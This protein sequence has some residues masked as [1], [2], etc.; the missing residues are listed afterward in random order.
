MIFEKQDEGDILKVSFKVSETDSLSQVHA[1]LSP[2]QSVYSHLNIPEMDIAEDIEVH[3]NYAYVAGGYGGI[4]VVSVSISQ[5]L[6]YKDH[7][8]ENVN[9]VR[10]L[11]KYEYKNDVSNNNADNNTENDI[12]ILSSRGIS[13]DE[14]VKLN[15]IPAGK[16]KGKH[17]IKG[18][19]NPAWL[20]ATNYNSGVL[21]YQVNDGTL[22]YIK[23]LICPSI[24]V[25]I[26]IKDDEWLVG[27]TNDS[28]Y[29]TIKLSDCIGNSNN[30][31]M[32][33]AALSDDKLFA[34]IVSDEQAKI[35]YQITNF[36]QT[37]DF[38]LVITPKSDRERKLCL[39]AYPLKD[40][41][42]FDVVDDKIFIANGFNGIAIAANIVHCLTSSIET[43]YSQVN[44]NFDLKKK[45]SSLK[46]S[47]F[48]Y[49]QSS[50]CRINKF[51]IP[52]DQS[53]RIKFTGTLVLTIDKSVDETNDVQVLKCEVEDEPSNKCT[54]LPG[55][56]GCSCRSLE[57]GK[58]YRVFVH[59]KDHYT[60]EETIT[61]QKIT[62]RTVKID[63]NFIPDQPQ[64]KSIL[65]LN[66]GWNPIGFPVQPDTKSM[67]R[68]LTA[69][70]S[71]NL[72]LTLFFFDYNEQE[73]RILKK[74]ETIQPGWGYWL[75]F[76]KTDPIDI[77]LTGNDIREYEINYDFDVKEGSRKFM[78]ISGINAEMAELSTDSMGNIGGLW[79]YNR[80]LKATLMELSFLSNR[81]GYLLN[82]NTAYWVKV[83]GPVRIGMKKE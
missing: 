58:E 23:N 6:E 18:T 55:G 32:T 13:E 4:F 27:K 50:L 24:L 11:C 79:N 33:I 78:F 9:Y 77:I 21:V 68:L 12:S 71:T 29:Y 49:S 54:T 59:T 83:L 15:K 5:E 51:S 48:I 44:F 69:N 52:H 36:P 56:E 57:A 76:P 2:D 47:L 35:D 74:N 60:I 80:N 73:Y 22:T 41:R 63:P 17:K 14:P 62:T 26:A 61:V 66:P 20:F 37:P 46:Y 42:S 38:E 10:R 72:T 7:Y 81:K 70:N 43:N 3:G 1:F 75:K 64:A 16:S 67:N 8:E 40:V 28:Q 30:L 45:D 53:G 65:T 25:D 34:S 19:D 82:K 31:T 39:M